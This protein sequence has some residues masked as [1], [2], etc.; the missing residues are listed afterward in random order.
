M[1]ACKGIFAPPTKRFNTP[2]LAA[3]GAPIGRAGAGLAL[4]FNT[5]LF[6]SLFLLLTSI[7][8]KKISLRWCRLI[9]KLFI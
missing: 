7:L 3:E 1:L 6:Y 5:F 2:Q 4:Q 8:A 9:C